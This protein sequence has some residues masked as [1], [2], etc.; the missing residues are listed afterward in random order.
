MRPAA[1]RRALPAVVGVALLLAGCGWHLVGRGA[2]ALDPRIRVIA[3]PLFGNETKRAEVDLRL[4][5]AVTNELL[6]RGRF[7]VVPEAEGADAVLAGVVKA[8]ETFN[9]AFDDEGRVT[10]TEVRVTAGFTFRNRVAD[11]VEWENPSYLFRQE[12]DVT[13]DPE[14]YTDQEIVA[15]EQVSRDFALSVVS[16]I[17]EGF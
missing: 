16:Q 8:Y 5:E 10:R 2:G 13:G 15:I 12:Y 7:K 17:L 4:T 14:T 6:R 9:V 1:A 11:R 3:V